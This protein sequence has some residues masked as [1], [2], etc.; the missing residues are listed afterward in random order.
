MTLNA[1]NSPEMKSLLMINILINVTE[2]KT[3]NPR[4]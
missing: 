3:E 4:G 1:H 2:K